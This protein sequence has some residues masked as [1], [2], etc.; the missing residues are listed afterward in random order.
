MARPLQQYRQCVRALSQ[1]LG[2]APLEETTALFEQVSE[3]AL[4]PAP[5]QRPGAERRARRATP[6]ELPLVGRDSELDGLLAAHR[7]AAESGVLAVVEGEAGIGKTRLCL[8]LGSAARTNGALV[9]AAQ[10]HEDEAG[11]RTRRSWR[12]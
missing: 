9:L 2:V 10:C 1:E 7:A 12:F 11:L 6:R 3:G 5:P 4:A 8:E